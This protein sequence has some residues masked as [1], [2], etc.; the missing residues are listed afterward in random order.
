MR[1][2]FLFLVLSLPLMAAE[3]NEI[4]SRIR[5]VKENVDITLDRLKTVEGRLIEQR[6]IL[7]YL[8]EASYPMDAA[9]WEEYMINPPRN[10]Y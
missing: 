1:K 2:I 4:L 8:L 3:E 7:L 6:E 10:N 5:E 9:K